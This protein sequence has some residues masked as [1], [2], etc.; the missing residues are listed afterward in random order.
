V[1]VLA[2]S[3]AKGHP[4]PDGNKRT[5]LILSLIFL[6][7]NGARLEADHEV[8]FDTLIEVAESDPAER[9]SV[10]ERLTAWFEETIVEEQSP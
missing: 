9:E 4:C 7:F 8:L 1:A 5:A 3:I 2:Y 10:L 6:Q